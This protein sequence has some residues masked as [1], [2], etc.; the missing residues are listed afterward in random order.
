DQGTADHEVLQRVMIAL[1]IEESMLDSVEDRSRQIHD[2]EIRTP[3]MITQS[4]S[5]LDESAWL[6]EPEPCSQEC[7]DCLAEGT[8]PVHLRMCITCGYVG[9]CDSSVGLHSTRHYRETR[10]P[11]MRSFESGEGW[12][13]CYIDELLD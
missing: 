9:C 12:R 4:C 1:D 11:V 5:H 8:T 13:W 10:H 2:A 6:P 7:V 3:H